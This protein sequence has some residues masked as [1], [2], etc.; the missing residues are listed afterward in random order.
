MRRSPVLVLCRI[1]AD[2]RI[3]GWAATPPG[4]RNWDLALSPY[5]AVPDLARLAPD[6]ILPAPGGKWEAIRAIFLARPD[7]LEGRDLVWLP[8]DDVE[9]DPATLARLFAVALREGLAL[10]QPALTPDSVF[11]HFVTVRHLL[12]ELRYTNFVEL[13]APLATPELLRAA[14]PMME[15]RAGAKG[16]DYVWGRLAPPPR[17]ERIAVIDAAP[18]SHRRPL[19]RTLA[20]AMAAAGRDLEEERRRFF[21]EHLGERYPRSRSLG[22]P[23]RWRAGL[24]GRLA[25]SL[26]GALTVLAHRALW[27]RAA[28]GRAAKTIAAQLLRAEETP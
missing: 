2:H 1:G 13:M 22:A 24:Q 3:G 20:G 19:G 28:L 7:L 6:E 10:S 27:R 23:G 5:E 9:A 26:A 12:T 21:A 15:G 14:L 11:S 8:D 25:V 18:V 16:M 17:R 4:A